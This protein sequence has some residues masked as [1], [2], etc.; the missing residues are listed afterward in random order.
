MRLRQA[1]QVDVPL[2]EVFVTPTVAGLAALVDAQLR[3]GSTA[4]PP[5]QPVPREDD[6]A[7]AVRLPL[8]FAQQRLWFLDQLEPGST[9][10]NIPS[11]IRMSGDLN[12]EALRQTLDALAGRHESLRTTFEAVNG[13][14]A[15]VI[16]A[17]A[18]LPLNMLDLSETPAEHKEAAVMSEAVADARKPFDLARGPL[19]RACLLRLSETDHVLVFTMHHIISDGW[20]TGV[21]VREFGELYAAFASARE[22][23]LPALGLQY[24]DYAVWQRAWLAGGDQ[25]DGED[26]R[27]PLEKQLAYWR[28][29]LQDAPALLEL[30]TDRPRPAVQSYQGASLPFELP[31][32]L[33]E[34]VREIS[35]EEGATVFMT[36]M[37][38]FQALLGRLSN[39]ADICVGTPVAN[40][41]HAELEGIIGFFVNTLVLR[42]RLRLRGDLSAGGAQVAAASFRDLL[43]QVRTNA[44]GAYAHQDVPFEK[45]VDALGVARNMAHSPLFQVMFVWQEQRQSTSAAPVHVPGLTLQPIALHGGTTAFDLT[46]AMADRVVDGRREGLNGWLEYATELFERSTIERFIRYFQALLAGM[47]AAPDQPIAHVEILSAE[48]RQTILERWN[49]TAAPVP[50]LCLHEAFERQAAVT[51]DAIALVFAGDD[52]TRAS[53]EVTYGELNGLADALACEL[54]RLG[55]EHE[56]IVAISVEKSVEQIAGLLGILKAGAAYL[57]IDPMYPAERIAY[58]LTDSGVRVLLTQTHLAGRFEGAAL[59]HVVCLDEFAALPRSAAAARPAALAAPA[60]L[61]YVIYTSGSTGQPKGVMVEHR[62]IVNHAHSLMTQTGIGPDDRLLQFVSLSFDAAGEE[63]YPTLLSG[64]TLVLPADSHDLVGAHLPAFCEQNGVT[65]LHMPAAVWH[66]IVDDLAARNQPWPGPLRL[67]MLGGDAPDA[68]RLAAFMKLLGRDIPFMNLYGPTEATI[69]TTS[70]RTTDFT[71]RRLPVGRPIANARVYVLDPAGQPA[72]VGVAGEI[73]IGGAG[74]ARGYLNRPELTG[75]K[76]VPA[77]WNS[78]QEKPGFWPGRLYRTGDLGRWLPDGNLEF[79]GRADDQVKIRGYRIELGEIEAALTAHPGVK[80][81]AVLA[82]AEPELGTTR[83]VAYFTSASEPPPSVADLRTFLL[84]TLPD[85]MAPALFVALPGL[86][87]N[88]HGKVDR[89]ALRD[90]PLPAAGDAGRAGSGSDFVAPATAAEQALAAIWSQV[91]GVPRVGAD[92]NFFELGGDSILSI[93]VVSRANQAGLNITPKQLFQAPTLAALAAL[94]GRPTPAWPSKAPSPAPCRSRPSSAGSSAWRWRTGTTGTSRCCLRSH[95]ASTRRPCGEQWPRLS[96]ITTRSGCGL[97]RPAAAGRPRTTPRTR[98]SPRRSTTWTSRTWPRGISRPRSSG[99]RLRRRSAWTFLAVHSSVPYTTTPDRAGPGAC[100][101]SSTTSRS[102]AYPGGCCW[103]ICRARTP[104]WPG[105]A[106]CSCRPRRAPSRHG[107]SGWW[108]T[109]GLKASLRSWTSGWSGRAAGFRRCPSTS[110]PAQ[111]TTPRP[112]RPR[113]ASRCRRR[114]PR[115]C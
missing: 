5:I 69:T 85:Y 45:L 53:R 25:V 49:N 115:R 40:R 18:S 78:T 97:P 71:P 114:T 94:A 20:S 3:A 66:G 30:P 93:Q 4:A 63:F 113:L 77:S 50:A 110:R 39:Q 52:A 87:L 13:K 56:D 10:Y 8:S 46:L 109:P 21:L 111:R 9:L 73:Y 35:R 105:R 51:P 81:C 42:S 33:A 12:L 64:A 58:L 15:Q 22:P 36:L 7:G 112:P 74:V 83:L 6:A 57:P 54:Q 108:H 48:E 96:S 102:T 90:A 47:L 16:S 23:G 99:W 62:S 91:L 2:R 107:P 84:R 60:S 17:T 55:V 14:P 95:A 19:V 98:R 1:F 92:D 68:G 32:E 11:A 100:C 38:V 24:A 34:R 65:I 103:K 72:P 27:S 88:M 104:R 82:R 89:A 41:T 26:A 101:S 44:L 43:R 106:R 80:E 59:R 31:E 75:A 29:A 86:P 79:L 67:L 76:F 61:A 28:A 37:A 70:Y